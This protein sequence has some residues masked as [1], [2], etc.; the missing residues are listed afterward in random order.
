MK[1]GLIPLIAFAILLMAEASA[2]AATQIADTTASKK[3]RMP[4]GNKA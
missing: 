3:S 2:G 1:L 4:G